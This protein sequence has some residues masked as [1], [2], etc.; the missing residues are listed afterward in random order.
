MLV[1][2][3]VHCL[4][5][6]PI[7]MLWRPWVWHQIRLWLVPDS[8]VLHLQLHCFMYVFEHGRTRGYSLV[9]FTNYFNTSKKIILTNLFTIFF[10][11]ENT[12][13]LWI[14]FSNVYGI[15]VRFVRSNQR[16]QNIGMCC[17]FAKHAVLEQGLLVSD[18]DNVSE[19]SDMSTREL[20]CFK[21]LALKTTLYS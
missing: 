17:F 13:Y 14:F 19:W 18:Q 15:Q 8:V 16:L 3:P 20:L 4:T 6:W 10:A 11:P 9:V 12:V 5:R 7:M 2:A 21:E 1:G